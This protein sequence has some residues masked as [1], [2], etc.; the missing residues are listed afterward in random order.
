MRVFIACGL[1]LTG[2]VRLPEANITR[3]QPDIGAATSQARHRPTLAS[4]DVSGFLHAPGVTEA[5]GR[6]RRS[7]CGSAFSVPATY[8]PPPVA[9]LRPALARAWI[10]CRARPGERVSQRRRQSHTVRHLCDRL[11]APQARRARCCRHGGIAPGRTAR[12]QDD[13]HRPGG[14]RLRP[15][16][17][18]V[19]DESRQAGGN[20]TGMFFRQPE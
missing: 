14:H 1:P 19:C 16:G 10:Q 8:A 17:A 18:G 5:D 4:W 7:L 11:G 12:H 20:I 15:D 6:R 2:G 13:P 9:R 3:E